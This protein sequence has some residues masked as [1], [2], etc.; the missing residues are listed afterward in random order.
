VLELTPKGE[1]TNA[2]NADRF[3]RELAA[4]E[5]HLDGAA[6]EVLDALRRLEAA[7]RKT[8]DEQL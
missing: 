4:L 8:L 3:V 2:R 5:R 6:D 7:L 1:A